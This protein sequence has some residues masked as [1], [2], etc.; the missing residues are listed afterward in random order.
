MRNQDNQVEEDYRVASEPADPVFYST[1][2]QMDQDRG[3]LNVPKIEP[4]V[5]K[6]DAGDQCVSCTFHAT[7]AKV[8]QSA[9]PNWFSGLSTKCADCS[10]QN[11]DVADLP[12]ARAMLAGRDLAVAGYGTGSPGTLPPVPV[13]SS[14]GSAYSN[15]STGGAPQ[16]GPD[17]NADTSSSSGVFGNTTYLALIIAVV[18]AVVLA[19]TIAGCIWYRRRRELTK[20]EVFSKMGGPMGGTELTMNPAAQW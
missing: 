2:W 17:P 11:A 8:N 20:A 1:C 12:T 16:L 5:P 13:S 19:F 10:I 3:F 9:V 15:S 18:V 6:W 4:T 7:L 14:T